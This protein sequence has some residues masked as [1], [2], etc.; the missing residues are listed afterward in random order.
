MPRPSEQ[1]RSTHRRTGQTRPRPRTRSRYQQTGKGLCLPRFWSPS[2]SA[3]LASN[4]TPC[5]IEMA[6]RPRPSLLNSERSSPNHAHL[7]ATCCK[8]DEGSAEHLT[9][10]RSQGPDDAR[11]G[12]VFPAIFSRRGRL[13]TVVPD[14]RL[15]KSSRPCKSSVVPATLLLSRHDPGYPWKPC[16]SL[17]VLSFSRPFFLFFAVEPAPARAQ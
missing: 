8:R 1:R 2:S 7:Y 9:G 12:F 3:E 5:G 10:L 14:A 4:P 16:L 17:G 13:P 11:I 6:Q 15:V